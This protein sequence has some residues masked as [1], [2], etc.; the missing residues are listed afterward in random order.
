MRYFFHLSDGNLIQDDAG[1]VC[2]TLEE[3][4]QFA[5]NVAAELGQNRD[6][7]DIQGEYVCVTDEDGTEVF[8][9]PL[10]NLKRM[11]KADNLGEEKGQRRRM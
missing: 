6:A 7:K 2:K 10:V 4:K 11:V 5:I 9:T 3:A 1:E 8:R